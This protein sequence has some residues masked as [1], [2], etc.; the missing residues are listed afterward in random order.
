MEKRGR[1]KGRK[2]GRAKIGKGEGLRLGEK[3]KR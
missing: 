1:I 3:E 2:R